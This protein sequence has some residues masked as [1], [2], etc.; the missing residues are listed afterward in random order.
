MAPDKPIGI[1]KERLPLPPNEEPRL[2]DLL[3]E[4]LLLPDLPTVFVISKRS[5]MFS[6]STDGAS[7]ACLL[8]S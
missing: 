7:S 3:K 8:T 1:A 6:G 5:S 2:T 4:I